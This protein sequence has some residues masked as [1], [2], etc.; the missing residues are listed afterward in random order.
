[1][2]EKFILPSYGKINWF[3][4]IGETRSDGYHEIESLMQKIAFSDEIEVSLEERERDYIACNFPIPTG[5]DGVLSRLLVELRKIAPPLREVGFNIKIKKSIPPGSGLGGGSSNVASILQLINSVF[6]L[7]LDWE[8]V[9]SIAVRIGSDIPFFARGAPF[10]WV[11][12]RGEEVEPLFFAPHRFLVLL[13]PPFSI[14]TAW[15]Y[16]CWEERKGRI[17]E[18]KKAGLSLEEFL[19]AKNPELIEEI[20]WNDF[21]EVVFQC[22]PDLNFYKR[23]LMELGCKKVFMSGSGST[24]VGVVESKE[25]GER[26]VKEISSPDVKAILTSTIWEAKEEGANQ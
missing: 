11:R 14:S 16:R 18:N 22:F 5:E 23:L 7:N 4:K 10:A 24:L 26:I 15:A 19:K 3:L 12:G 8:E 9:K 20:I 25:E 13:F 1:M 6:K 2:S 21:E 17:K